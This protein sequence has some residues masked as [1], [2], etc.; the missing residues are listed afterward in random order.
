MSLIYNAEATLKRMLRE[1]TDDKIEN[2]TCIIPAPD[3][4]KIQR[5]INFYADLVGT[6]LGIALLVFVLVVGPS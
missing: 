2:M 3:V 6:L 4:G 1:A 5:V